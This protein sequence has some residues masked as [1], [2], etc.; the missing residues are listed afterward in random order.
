MDANVLGDDVQNVNLLTVIAS[1]SYD[2]FAKGL[3]SEM[4][5]DVSDRHTQSYHRS[6]CQ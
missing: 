2:S 1:E 4:A 6:L 3:Q 5:E